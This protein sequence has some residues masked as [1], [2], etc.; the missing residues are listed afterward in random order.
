MPEIFSHR[1]RKARKPSAI[2]PSSA[3]DPAKTNASSASATPPV[4][5][6]RHVDEYSSVMRNEP[7]CVNPFAS[8][9]P[10]P[11]HVSFETQQKEEHIILALRRHPITLV[12]SILIIILMALAPL[13][14]PFVPIIAFFP[15]NFQLMTVVGWYL[16]IVGYSLE[17]FLSWFFNVNIITDE[18][19][20]DIDFLSLI[21][22]RISSAKIDNIEDVTSTTGGFIR[23]LL[24]F[25]TVVVQTAG[26]KREF[27]FTDVPQ[28]DKVVQLLNELIMEEER[29]KMEGRVN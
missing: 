3:H 22:K 27:E 4:R 10:K 16:M 2:N 19:I 13:I 9:S 15:A 11:I 25:G 1:A 20:V 18:R 12:P 8:F 6:H 17:V 21:F 26:E 5:Q 28:P 23:S 14:L 7:V 24:S 29:E